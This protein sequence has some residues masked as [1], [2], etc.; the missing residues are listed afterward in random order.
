MERER[1][2]ET[3]TERERETDRQRDRDRVVEVLV[4]VAI[5]CRQHIEVHQSAQANLVGIVNTLATARSQ[6][7]WPRTGRKTTSHATFSSEIWL[8]IQKRDIP[9]GNLT[10][11]ELENQHLI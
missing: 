6:V 8:W 1:E 2:T 9:S 4:L 5:G 7:G 11:C 10:L 3:E